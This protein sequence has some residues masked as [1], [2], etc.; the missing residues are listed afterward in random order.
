MCFLLSQH[1]NRYHSW[2]V[3][4][5]FPSFESLVLYTAGVGAIYL[6]LQLLTWL[7]TDKLQ[8]KGFQSGQ[9]EYGSPPSLNYWA[10]QA[11]VHVV[12]LTSMRLFVVLLLASRRR[13]LDIGAWV[14]S[15]VGQR[16]H[17]PSRLV[18]VHPGTGIIR[19]KLK[20]IF[21]PQH[22]GYFPDIHECCPVLAHRLGLDS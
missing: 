9:S 15:L 1:S 3:S 17:Y 2:C 8:F 5:H 12:S 13:L 21:G 10:R 4:L 22:D 11:A 14:L 19:C 6:A 16:R 18:R 7:F 20:A